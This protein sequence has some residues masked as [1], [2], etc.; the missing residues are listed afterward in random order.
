MDVQ[1]DQSCAY[2]Y[3]NYCICCIDVCDSA[4]YTSLNAY[5]EYHTSMCRAGTGL[6]LN[7]VEALRY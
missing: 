1:K 6:K 2:F 7:R 4:I 5:D 3:A